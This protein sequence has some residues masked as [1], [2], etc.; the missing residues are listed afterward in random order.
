MRQ[1]DA[2]ERTN[3]RT[4][5][6]RQ[7]RGVG[8]GGAVHD[9][10]GGSFEGRDQKSAGRMAEVVVEVDRL[11]PTGAKFTLK[12]AGEKEE[13]E[14]FFRPCG[15]S[16]SLDAAKGLRANHGPEGQFGPASNLPIFPWYC[17]LVEILPGQPRLF[18]AGADGLNRQRGDVLTPEKPLFFGRGQHLP[19]PH[20]GGRRIMHVVQPQN[21]HLPL[22]PSLHRSRKRR[23]RIPSLPERWQGAWQ[24][25]VAF[26]PQFRYRGPL[27]RG[28]SF[29]L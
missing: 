19:V 6:C 24:R 27:L 11:G 9:Q 25:L 8:F 16:A 2:H 14:P 21:E 17:D 28:P 15:A 3:L 26:R 20:E 29:W 10:D 22:W 23:V 18:Q 7:H 1:G 4:L 12:P 5:S 13:F